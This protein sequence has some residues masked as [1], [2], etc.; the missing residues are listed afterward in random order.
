MPITKSAKK[1]L[2]SSA[3]K[4]ASNQQTLRALEIAIKKVTGKNI[5]DVVSKI[6]K[7]AKKR[8][9]SKNKASRIKSRISKR[10]NVV[11]PAKKSTSPIATKPKVKVKAG[12]GNKSK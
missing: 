10:V 5:A 8:V 1:S 11:K 12:K 3:A 9:I 6:D 7:A 2:R 4:R